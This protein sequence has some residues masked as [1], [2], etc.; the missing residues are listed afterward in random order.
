MTV[1]AVRSF[2]WLLQK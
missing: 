2:S 1:L